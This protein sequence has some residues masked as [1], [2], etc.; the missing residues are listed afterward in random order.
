MKSMNRHMGKVDFEEKPDAAADP[1][2]GSGASPA[3][4]AKG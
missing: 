3:S 2:T 4:P 1:A